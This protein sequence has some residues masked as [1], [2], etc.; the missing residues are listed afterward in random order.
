MDEETSAEDLESMVARYDL[1][2]PVVEAVSSKSV[3]GA[4]VVEDGASKLVS[5]TKVSGAEPED[6]FGDSFSDTDFEAAEAAATQ[7]FQHSAS[8]QASVRIK[9]L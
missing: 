5:L 6:E 2:L 9:F 3:K 1:G 8:S 7:S 4:K